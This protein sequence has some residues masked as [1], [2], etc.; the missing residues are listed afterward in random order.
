MGGLTPG[1]GV[2]SLH[3][4][5]NIVKTYSRLPQRQATQRQDPEKFSTNQTDAPF[6]VGRGPFRKASVRRAE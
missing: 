1:Q 3:L 2:A 4:H 6:P 5:E